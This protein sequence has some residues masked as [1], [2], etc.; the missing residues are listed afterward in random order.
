MLLVAARAKTVGEA[1]RAFRETA[2]GYGPL[3][4]YLQLNFDDECYV[5]AEDT[6]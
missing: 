4:Y 3:P 2:K 5:M 6:S 1:Y